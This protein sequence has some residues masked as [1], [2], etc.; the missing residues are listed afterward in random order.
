MEGMQWPA[1]SRGESVGGSLFDE[2]D[3]VFDKDS[4]WEMGVGV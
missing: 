3:E 2:G 4:D 1:E